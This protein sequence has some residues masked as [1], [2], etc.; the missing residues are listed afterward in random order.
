MECQLSFEELKRLLIY[1]PILKVVGLEKDFI[2][3]T[4]VCQQGVGGVLMQDD[5]VVAYKS[6][7]LKENEQRY[8]TY[9]LDLIVVIHALKVWL[10]YL[11]GK[12]FMLMT[13]HSSLTNFFKQPNLNSC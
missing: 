7:K 10:H 5:K 3:C 11:L 4:D 1:G 13:D 8:S 9:D 6:R 12:K 2:V